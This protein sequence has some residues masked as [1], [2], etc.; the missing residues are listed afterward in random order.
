MKKQKWLCRGLGACIMMIGN[1]R[2]SAAKVDLDVV[3]K[4]I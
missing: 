2:A 4:P 3:C 1:D